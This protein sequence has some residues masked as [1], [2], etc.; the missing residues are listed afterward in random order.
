MAPTI[1]AV[2]RTTLGAAG[3]ADTLHELA[4]EFSR[5][6]G[7][8]LPHDG[9]AC[10]MGGVDPATGTVVMRAGKT[11]YGLRAGF[12]MAHHCRTNRYLNPALGGSLAAMLD[13][14][15]PATRAT[16]AVNEL[17]AAE[18][19]GIDLR[20]AL[21][22]RGRTWGA[23]GLTREHGANPFTADEIRYA[24]RLSGP[25]TAAVRRFA[26]GIPTSPARGSVPGTLV[27][28]RD[29]RITAATP[30]GREWLRDLAANPARGGEPGPEIVLVNPVVAARRGGPP[31]VSTVPTSRGWASIHAQ[32]LHGARPGDVAV[33]VQT[34][35][36]ADLLSAVATCRG[37]TDREKAVVEQA[38]GGL[39]IKQIARRLDLSAHTVNDYFKAI[40]R[41]FGVTSREELF[42][43]LTR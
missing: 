41:K 38:L 13:S 20:I 33:T 26:A 19:I 42:T 11:G 27:L 43:V 34:A 39:P 32:P 28:D 16:E 35:S 17:M 7:P 21:T 23:F 40:Y 4:A 15:R 1:D 36:A 30:A 29:D 14:G 5:I 3:E 8:G 9:Y 25:L 6:L 31:A 22:V 2:S 10:L 18:G 37:I 24:E 12:R